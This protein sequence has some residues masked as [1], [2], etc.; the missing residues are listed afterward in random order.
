MDLETAQTNTT[1]KLPLLKHGE[2]DMWKLRIQQYFQIQDYALWDVIENGNSFKPTAQT[3]TNAKGTST[4]LIP[5]L[6]TAN[7]K[8]QKKND[9]K[10][11]SMLLMAL[12]NEHLLTF[13]QYKDAKTLF[14]AI[15]TR[16]GGNDT[17]KKTQK[18][19][20]KQ[21]YKN[22]SSPSTE[23]LDSI[24]NRLQKIYDLEDI[25]LKWQLALL[26]MRTRKFFQK[27]GRK[28][29]INGSDTAEYDKSKVE[30]FNCHK[31]GHFARECRGPKNQD[32][33]SRNQ[34]NS[35]RTINVEEI[36]SKAMLAIDGAGFNWSFMADEEVPT[37]MALMAFSDSEPE[38]KGYRPKASKSVSEDTSNEGKESPDASL[39][40]E[41]V[42]N[43]KL[44]KKTVF[45]T[46]NC[47]YHQME[48]MVSTKVNYN[49]SAKKTH[50]SAHRNIVPRAVLMKTGLR[51]LNTARPVNTAH[52]KTTVYSAK[53]MSCFS[54]STQSTIKRPYSIKTALTNKN[55]SQKVNTGK[56]SFYTARPKAVNTARPNSAV[57]NAVR[58]N[59]VNVVKASACWVWRPTKLNSASI[60]LKRHN[61]V[62][63]R[64]RSKSVSDRLQHVSYL[65]QTSERLCKNGVGWRRNR[66]LIEAARTMLADSKLPTTFWA[67]AVNTA[68]YVQNSGI[69]DGPK[70]LFDID[71]LTK[72]INYVP[73]VAGTNSNDSVGTKESA[74]TDHSIEETRSREYYILMPLWKDGSL[75]DFSSKDAGNDEPQ[76]SND[77]EKK[78]DEGG[79]DDQ[80]RTE[81][82]PIASL[83]S[84]Y[85]DFFGDES[86][87][88]LSNIATTYPVATTPNTRIHKYHSLDH[89]LGDVQSSVQTRR[90]INEQGFIRRAQEDL[91]YGKRAIRRKWMY[92]NKKDKRGIV[93]RNKTRL[94][95]HGYTQEEGIDYDEIFALVTRIEAIRIFQVTPKVSHLHAVKRIF[96]YLKGQPKLG[97]WYPKDSPFNL[98]AYT[99]SDYVGAS[100]D[101]KSTTRV[102]N[103][104]FH[105]TTKHIEIRH[106][107][108]R[109]SYKKRL[110]QVI[111]IHTD[112]NVADLLTKAFDIDDWNR[113]KM[114]RMKLGLKLVTH[115]V[116]AAGH[117]LVLLGEKLPLELQLLRYGTTSH[118]KKVFEN[119]RRQGKD[120]SGTVIPLFTT[121]LIQPQADVGEDETV[122]AERGDSM[123]R[124]AIIVSSLDAEQDSGVNTPRSGEDIMKLNELMEICTKLSDRVLALENVNT[125]QDLEITSLKKRVKKLEKK[126]KARTLQLKRRLFKVRIESSANKSLGDQEDASKQ[127]R[128]EDQDDDISLFQKDVETQ[129]RY[130]HD[131]NITTAS[132]PITTVGVSVNTVES[133]TPPTTTLIKDE[134]LTIA[135]TL[136]KMRSEKSKEK[137][138]EK[139]KEIRLEREREEEASNATLIEEC[140]NVQAMMDADYELATRI[141]AQE[142]GELSI[143]ESFEEIQKLFNIEM[144]RV[145]TFVP[146][147]S[148]VVKGSKKKAESSGKEAASKKRAGEKLDDKSVKKQKIEDDAEKEELRACLDIIS[149]DDVA[150]NI[151]RANGCSKNYKIFSEMLNDFGRHDVLDL[152]RLVMERF[153]TTSLEGYDR[154]LWGDLT[155]LFEPSEEDEI[156]KAQ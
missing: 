98:E 130:A 144:K 66:T 99:D 48:R 89:V 50:L 121:M 156:W 5:G 11:R 117:Y 39:A 52:P 116:N 51:P 103:P 113:L 29:T 13:N 3:T 61:Y 150:I 153:K 12:L 49:Y 18:T 110:I 30:C 25:D 123:E 65:S 91:P 111:K 104:V 17:T 137:A 62:D 96:R 76:P 56:G 44:E 72:S 94:V 75:F 108:I 134:D 120:F 119:M 36:S 155:T 53:P 102:K 58:E 31:L 83:E 37:N 26:S 78:D 145:D 85:V 140:H 4:T 136:M 55:Y 80:E 14:A 70:W 101:K 124:A 24:F 86:E 97:L 20:L 34:D 46:A 1:I 19:L 151:I 41:L 64:G 15:Q 149:G 57:V 127:G 131:I 35:K 90:M 63:A 81:K 139:D 93:I 73:V 109:D 9:M 133:S 88:D 45:L 28:I 16:F 135:Q 69:R 148:D 67:E 68:C 8:T 10:A 74:S 128:N 43:D 79:I 132:A 40:E 107:F 129:G 60:T 118:T 138:K 84:T 22:F 126:K 147:D 77:A 23:S 6:V 32:N 95:A 154:L 71:L 7:E 54:K 47:N 112:H 143:E 125:A 42:S 21:M 100:F 105:L 152:Y 82:I 27:T 59:Q 106:H 114:L 38:F 141:Q 87:L 33:M 92:R 122:H 142:R 146:M 115:K 2:Y